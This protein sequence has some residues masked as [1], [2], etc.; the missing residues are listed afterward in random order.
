MWR[1]F[2]KITVTQ[3]IQT[4]ALTFSTT[5]N[6]SRSKGLEITKRGARDRVQHWLSH[7]FQRY[8]GW[9]KNQSKHR[10]KQWLLWAMLKKIH[11]LSLEVEN[12]TGTEAKILLCLKQ[13]QCQDLKSGLNWALSFSI[14]QVKQMAEN[15]NLAPVSFQLYITQ[16]ERVEGLWCY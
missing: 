5:H 13:A 7:H 12:G 15:C 16:T 11:L 10:V 8:W 1:I 9:N 2:T 14:Y 6:W 3:L 4:S